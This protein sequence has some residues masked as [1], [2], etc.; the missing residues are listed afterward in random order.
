ME[1][2]ALPLSRVLRRLLVDSATTIGVVGDCAMSNWGGVAKLWGEISSGG[3]VHGMG[4][5][6]S[7]FISINSAK[8]EVGQTEEISDNVNPMYL[9]KAVH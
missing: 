5:S 6:R 7:A 9:N 8:S 1:R 3:G 2:E 4:V